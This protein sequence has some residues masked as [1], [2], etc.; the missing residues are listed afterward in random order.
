[1]RTALATKSVGVTLVFASVCLWGCSGPG[2]ASSHAADDK[3]LRDLVDRTVAAAGRR[4]VAEYGKYY[5]PKWMTALPGVPVSEVT[6]P[7]KMQFATGYA[8]KMVTVKTDF[9][10]AGDFGYALGTYEQ[11][12]PDKSGTLQNTVGKWMSVF[13]KQPDGSWG[14]V[15]DTYN[16]DPAP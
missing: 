15:A 7:L 3:A 11:T 6:G 10:D 2:G 8:I 9:S 12:A 13:R 5:G 1:M 16:V 4:D 14:A